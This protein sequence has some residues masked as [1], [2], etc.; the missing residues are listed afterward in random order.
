MAKHADTQHRK[1]AIK[2]HKES[3]LWVVRQVSGVGGAISSPHKLDLHLTKDLADKRSVT[4]RFSF[5]GQMSGPF[6]T[7]FSLTAVFQPV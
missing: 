6:I 1:K 2:A 7:D 3:N 5:F 4:N